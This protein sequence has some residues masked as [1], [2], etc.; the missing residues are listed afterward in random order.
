MDVG[1]DHR[2][3]Q[4]SL[5]DRI[6]QQIASQVEPAAADETAELT[7]TPLERSEPVIEAAA[8]RPDNASEVDESP[9]GGVLLAGSWPAPDISTQMERPIIADRHCS[10]SGCAEIAAVTLSYHYA[11]SQVWIDHLTPERDPHFYDLCDRHADRLSV[12]R[13]WHLDD[14]RGARRGDL[15]AV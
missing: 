10:R 3:D 15:I 1:P 14:R 11:T 4:H 12:M 5:F 7:R 13:G 9:P 6:A 8:S 2:P